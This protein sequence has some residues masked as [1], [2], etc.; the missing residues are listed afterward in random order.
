MAASAEVQL[1]GRCEIFCFEESPS[2]SAVPNTIVAADA[3]SHAQNYHHENFRI[4]ESVG[5]RGLGEMP[6]TAGLSMPAA[7]KIQF[8]DAARLGNRE[9]SFVQLTRT[10]SDFAATAV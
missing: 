8:L 1:D 6:A 9:G 5:S 2:V 10:V 7:A 4:S 3:C